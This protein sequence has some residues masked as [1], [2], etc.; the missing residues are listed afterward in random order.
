MQNNVI[1]IRE[2]HQ[3]FIHRL[4]KAYT[5]YLLS[6]IISDKITFSFKLKRTQNKLNN[7]I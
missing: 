3:S 7:K 4:T 2:C 6:N 5:L 1:D